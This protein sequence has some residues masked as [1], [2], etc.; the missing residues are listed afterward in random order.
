MALMASLQR[1]D[2]GGGG[3]AD[4]LINGCLSDSRTAGAGAGAGAQV[5]QA[6]GPALLAGRRDEGNLA[7]WS[8]RG[9][10]WSLAL[11]SHLSTAGPVDPS[12]QPL[13]SLSAA[14]RNMFLITSRGD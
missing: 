3:E 14:E 9:G 5:I 4:V 6:A 1:K 13:I 10:R 8:S 11:F 7:P 12:V 2:G